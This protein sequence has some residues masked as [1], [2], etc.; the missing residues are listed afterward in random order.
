[1]KEL[2]EIIAKAL[3]DYPETVSVK[4]TDKG[5]E[6]LL[7]LS[8]ANEDMGKVIGKHGRIAKAIRAIMKAQAIKEN[9]RIIVEIVQ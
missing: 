6:I 5:N 2:L 7:E 9:K 4:E 1:M 3:V 8:V